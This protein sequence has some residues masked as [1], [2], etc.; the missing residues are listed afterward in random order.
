M[1][2]IRFEVQG[3]AP[4]PYKVVFIRWEPNNISA[5]CSCPA[6]II[7]Q[8]CKHRFAI[9]EGRID[10]IVSTNIDDVRFVQAWLPGSDVEKA[11]F[12]VRNLEIEAARIKKEISLA[13]KDVAKAFRD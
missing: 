11:L 9:L 12:K 5:Y 4:N 13:K 1:E 7:G 3:S 8:Y 6:G 2:E 10:G